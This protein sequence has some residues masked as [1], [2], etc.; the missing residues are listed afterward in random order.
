MEKKNPVTAVLIGAGHRSV[1]YGN[2]SLSHPEELKIVGIAEPDREL[3]ENVAKRFNVPSENLF[4]NAEAFSRVPRFADAAING[5]M[6]EVHVSTTVPLLDDGY[7]V[8]LEKPFATN[9]AEF[10]ILDD[11]VRRNNSK[12]MVCH[13]LRYADFYREIK[14][15]II[16]GEIGDIINIQTVENISYHHMSTSYVRGKWANELL[17]G[18]SILLAK[19]SHDI[20]LMVWLMG[21]EKPDRVSS[22]GSVMQFKE[23]NA[24]R[25]SG[26]KC[27]VD[28]K[29]ESECNYSAR[30]LYFDHPDRWEFYVW[31]PIMH[32]G[33]KP[34][35]EQRLDFLK[36]ESP[37]GRCVY[38][39]N[40][41]VVDHQTVM[42]Q[43]KN[44]AIGTHTLVGGTPFP[45]RRINIT[46]TR[47]SIFGIFEDSRFTVSLID[48]SPDC[49]HRDEIVDLSGECSAFVNH[50]GG[51]TALVEDFVRFVR[52]E[53]PSISCTDFASSEDGHRII[54]A[55]DRS[56]KCGGQTQIL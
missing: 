43:F 17:S 33:K 51:D 16:S 28:C 34:T 18:S 36:G 47:G 31:N 12:L 50:G 21:N 2:Y 23:E 32:D 3:R 26:T 35:E 40:N 11:A 49:E 5:T 4:E 29:I 46:G 24:P 45:Q 14:K 39:S 55:A 48:P 38:R 20:D 42:I 41:T 15:R 6:D 19:C 27:L 13:V 52:G 44:G 56:M 22:F 7:S 53:A 37:F 9:E 54:F 8:L 30:K 25:G 10:K 1:I